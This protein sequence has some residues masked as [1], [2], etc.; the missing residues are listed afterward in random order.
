M[1]LLIHV[2]LL[3]CVDGFAANPIVVVISPLLNHME[4]QTNFLRAH[5]ISAGLIG[6]DKAACQR[7]VLCS[8]YFT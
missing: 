1:A 7:K 2:G 3:T 5:G 6:E 8:V 4:D